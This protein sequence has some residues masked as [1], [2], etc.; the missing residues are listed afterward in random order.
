MERKF[1]TPLK[2]FDNLLAEFEDR[3]DGCTV[4][5]FRLG[6]GLQGVDGRILT[7]LATEQH[8]TGRYDN[9]AEAARIIERWTFSYMYVEREG[10]LKELKALRPRF[11]VL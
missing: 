9:A 10:T 8:H 1:E 11:E 7:L 3:S 4:G 5:V 6:S 2:A